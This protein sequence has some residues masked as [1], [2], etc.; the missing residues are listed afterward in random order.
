MKLLP[1]HTGSTSY[2][3][4]ARTCGDLG[5][6]KATREGKPYCP[7]HVGK[8]S[9]A[10]RV[11]QDIAKRTAEDQA[12]A[13][14]ITPVAGYNI[15]GITA[16]AILQQL[17]EFGVR[18]KARLCRELTLERGV[19]DGYVKALLKR[20]LVVEGVNKRGVETLRLRRL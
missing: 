3:S 13:A 5:C 9:H 17:D 12:V 20:G 11:L 14:G 10:N 1:R 19:L 18:T 7:D 6:T 2:T 8:N 16:R 4:G 15:R